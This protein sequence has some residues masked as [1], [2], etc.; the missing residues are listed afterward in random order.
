MYEW[1]Y[2]PMNA[3]DYVRYPWQKIVE[4]KCLKD[5]NCAR[6]WNEIE[7]WLFSDFFF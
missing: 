7:R 4:K 5:V 3:Y 1:H 2:E 6:K